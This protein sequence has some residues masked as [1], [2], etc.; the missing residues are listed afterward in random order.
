VTSPALTSAFFNRTYDEAMALLV[1]ARNYMAFRESR[2]VRGMAPT[3][4][5]KVSH[6]SMRMTCRLTQIMAWMLAQKAMHAGEIT[7]YE[8]AGVEYAL[9]GA[10]VCLDDRGQ[11]DNELPGALRSLLERSYRLY[12]RV[13][14]LDCQVRRQAEAEAAA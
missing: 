4:R 1:E 12:V 14:R 6:E 13:A 8:A 9:S 10:Q 7:L 11:G 5:L 2:D 3:S